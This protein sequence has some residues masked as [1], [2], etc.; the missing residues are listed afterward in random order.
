MS[1]PTHGHP[2]SP[3]LVHLGRNRQI[4]VIRLVHI[5]DWQGA[6]PWTETR[7]RPQSYLTLVVLR[8]ARIY[9]AAT[10][11]TNEEWNQQMTRREQLQTEQI[12]AE[13]RPEFL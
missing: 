5:T 11:Y 10:K 12:N 13:Q 3:G 6:I 8:V 2:Q 9:A 1:Y 4:V 7:T